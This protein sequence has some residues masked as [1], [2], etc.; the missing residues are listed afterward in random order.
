[1]R[2]ITIANQKGG[3]GKTTT[4]INLSACLAE[5]G[6]KVLLIDMDPQGHAGAGLNIRLG[7]DDPTI[8]EVLCSFDD[9]TF[10]LD[11]IAVKVNDNFYVAPSSLT[12]SMLEQ[13]MSMAEGRE[14][15]L[16]QAIDASRKDYDYMV[17]DC[18]PSLGLLTFNSLMAATEVFIPIDMGFFSLHGT[19]RLLEIIDM[20]RNKTGHVIRTKVIATKYDRRTRIAGEMLD[21][22]KDYFD[23]TLFNTVINQNVTLQEAVLSGKSIIDYRKNSAGY[24][25][26]TA[27]ANEVIGEEI[28]EIRVPAAPLDRLLREFEEKVPLFPDQEE[29]DTDAV[30]DDIERPPIIMPEYP[31]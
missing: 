6:R 13:V 20:V 26:Y 5:Q 4:A 19:G 24:R 16:K 22:I 1:M 12:L 10:P 2:V 27:L 14:M 8:Y 17:I 21:E 29:C 7:E 25:D 3:C 18:P 23:G 15:R 28:P 30:P 11:E 9:E 31:S